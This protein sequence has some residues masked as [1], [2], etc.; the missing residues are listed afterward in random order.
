MTEVDDIIQKIL[1]PR[2]KGAYL[3]SRDSALHYNFE[4]RKNFTIKI[5]EEIL[6]NR[7]FGIYFQKPTFLKQVFDEKLH[8]FMQ[9]GLIEWW[10][11]SYTEKPFENTQSKHPKQI[12]LNELSG[13]YKILLFGLLLSVL[14]F[15]LEIFSLKYKSLEKVF[16]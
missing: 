1:D 15:C 14:V 12:K 8:Q 6:Y 9:Y 13:L 3:A 10:V 16:S 7:Q 4:N 11:D 5:C 2:F